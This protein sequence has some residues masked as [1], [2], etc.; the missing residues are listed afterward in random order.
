MR[1]V[2]AL[3]MAAACI[4]GAAVLSKPKAQTTNG[5]KAEVIL[6]SSSSG[7]NF[8]SAFVNFS[9]NTSLVEVSFCLER[10]KDTGYR[11]RDQI[12]NGQFVVLKS[13][14]A[15]S[16]HLSGDGAKSMKSKVSYEGAI[17]NKSDSAKKS[18]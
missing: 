15:N 2:F 11:N 16:W 13:A 17:G 14:Y 9:G 5:V 12:R 18:Y 4:L 6:R 7:L 3:F 10:Y 8:A 1:K